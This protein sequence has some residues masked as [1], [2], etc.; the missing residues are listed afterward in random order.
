MR[1]VAAQLD[2]GAH[3]LVTVGRERDRKALAKRLGLTW[4]GLEK[5]LTRARDNG[6]TRATQVLD[7]TR[8]TP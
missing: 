5:A 6:D 2:A 7:E 1:H 3:W 8:R 4:G